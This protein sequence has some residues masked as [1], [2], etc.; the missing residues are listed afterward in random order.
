MEEVV[1]ASV[2][3]RR[4]PTLLLTGFALLALALAAVGIAGVVAYSVVQQ[5][6]EIGLRMA[7]GAQPR[8]VMRLVVGHSMAWTLGGLA[9]GLGASFGVLRLLRSLLFGVTPTDPVV[10]AAVSVLLICVALAAS[11][12]PARR[13]LRVDPVSALRCQ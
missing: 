4:F 8:D 13:A 9:V 10:L 2:S 11:Y 7:L 5:S 3:S 6:Q 12:L 1:G